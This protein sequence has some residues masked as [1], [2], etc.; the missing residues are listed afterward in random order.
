MATS[1][2]TKRANKK[3]ESKMVETDPPMSATFVFARN[4]GAANRKTLAD[5]EELHQNWLKLKDSGKQ[6]MRLEFMIGYITGILGQA[7]DA[8]ETVI[9]GRVRLG[10]KPTPSKPARTPEQQ[11]AYD[12]ARKMFSFHISRDDKRVVERTQ[13]PQIKLSADFKE[14]AVA[15]VGQFYEEVNAA[16]IADMIKRLR[17]LQK[18]IDKVLPEVVG[19]GEKATKKA[20]QAA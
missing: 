6:A 11:R 19:D 16:S 9:N 2:A 18:R 14:A 13:A 7:R 8:A 17:A 12:A 3:D 5:S 20:R 15:F 10:A 1:T 4:L